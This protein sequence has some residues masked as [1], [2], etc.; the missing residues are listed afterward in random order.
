M[1]NPLTDLSHVTEA[2]VDFVEVQVNKN[3]EFRLESMNM[4]STQAMVTLNWLFA[5]VV[6]PAGYVFSKADEIDWW[7]AFPALTCSAS[8][9][10]AAVYL[11]HNALR[12]KSFIPTGNEP[13]NLLKTELMAAS[14]NQ[15][16]IAE[17]WNIQ[18][19]LEI[20][21]AHNAR[22]A[23]ALDNART[24]IIAITCGSIILLG[25]TYSLNVCAEWVP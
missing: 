7:I 1:D 23:R 3:L 5:L 18:E 11:F 14:M 16:R 6:T 9:A 21:K 20:V 13:R 25:L 19:R 8:S 15:I 10:A 24:A 22:A 2:K 17:I 4:L 12:V